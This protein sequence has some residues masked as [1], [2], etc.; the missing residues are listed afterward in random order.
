[1]Q[2]SLV[3]TCWC[4]SVGLFERIAA[5]QGVCVGAEMSCGSLLSLGAC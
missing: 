5:A 1:M 2:Q 4:D 3:A